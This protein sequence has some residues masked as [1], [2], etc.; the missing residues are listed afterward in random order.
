MEGWIL[1]PEEPD[2]ALRPGWLLRAPTRDRTVP[3]SGYFSCIDT[4]PR[5]TLGGQRWALHPG[6]EHDPGGTILLLSQN[7]AG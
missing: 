4:A 3:S 7:W 2:P 1:R 5:P 6:P